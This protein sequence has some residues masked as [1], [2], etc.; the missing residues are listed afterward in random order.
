M[1]QDDEIGGSTVRFADIRFATRGIDLRGGPMHSP[2]LGE[3][4]GPNPQEVDS[5]PTTDNL[6]IGNP[7]NYDRGAVSIAGNLASDD[8]VDCI[9]SEYHVP[10][11]RTWNRSRNNRSS[12]IS[13]TPTRW[14]RADTNLWVFQANGAVSHNV[15][16]WLVVIRIL[17]MTKSAPQRGADAADITRGSFGSGDAFIGS[18][19]LPMEIMWS[20]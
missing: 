16:Y 18:A 6:N 5:N 14:E 11:R 4:S 13:I 20:R 19:S 7:F 2:L 3:L 12:S 8:D 10:I 17:P 15:W 9:D 1:R